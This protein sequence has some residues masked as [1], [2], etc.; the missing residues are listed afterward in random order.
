MSD[1]SKC[2]FRIII[3]RTKERDLNYSEESHHLLFFSTSPSRAR[4]RTG[5]PFPGRMTMTGGPDVTKLSVYI[6]SEH[7]Q[8][9]HVGTSHLYHDLEEHGHL[10]TMSSPCP[11]DPFLPDLV[12][13]EG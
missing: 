4:V 3:S 10:T 8:R 2:I 11:L 1:L 9:T 13:Y 7:N 6:F 5:N 12:K